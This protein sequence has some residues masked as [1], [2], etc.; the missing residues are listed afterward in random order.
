M[1][2][3]Q[4]TLVA[5]AGLVMG[6]AVGLLIT[7][8]GL[9]LVG[10]PWELHFTAHH[11]AAIAV[12]LTGITVVAQGI[13]IVV[14]LLPVPPPSGFGLEP[15]S[16][17]PWGT[18]AL[19]SGATAPVTGVSAGEDLSHGA[20]PLRVGCFKTRLAGRP[21]WLSCPAGKENV[22]GAQRMLS[23]LIVLI[24]LALAVT[25]WLLRFT[26]DRIARLD[27]VIGGVVVA[28]LGIAMVYMAQPEATR[29]LSH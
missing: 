12:A 8:L 21:V 23:W 5:M 26:G 24:G 3:L 27:V 6:T 16:G 28:L 14:D 2:N 7:T 29:R 13:V 15:L 9:A 11:V 1:K 25:P 18:G 22:M 4:D 17:S 19:A 10:L 20:A